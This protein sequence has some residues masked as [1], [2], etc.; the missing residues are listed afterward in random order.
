MLEAF[1]AV[2]VVVGWEEAHVI[3]DSQTGLMQEE[4][5]PIAFESFWSQLQTRWCSSTF[6]ILP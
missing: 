3:R 4:R 1:G 5:D 2:E 6:K